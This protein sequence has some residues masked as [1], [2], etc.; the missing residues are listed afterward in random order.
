MTGIMKHAQLLTCLGRRPLNVGDDLEMGSREAF[1]QGVAERLIIG[2]AAEHNDR[3]RS[4]GKLGNELIGEH[5]CA[6]A[7]GC[8]LFGEGRPAE[9]EYQREQD[10]GDAEFLKSRHDAIHVAPPCGRKT[11]FSYTYGA[12]E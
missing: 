9:E 7:A 8:R 3:G 4:E 1:V 10:S 6:R 2:T 11:S 5:D 12:L